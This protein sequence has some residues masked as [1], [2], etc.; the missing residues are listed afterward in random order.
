MIAAPQTTHICYCHTTTRYLWDYSQ[1]Y[2]EELPLNKFFK[3]IINM[4]LSR[5]RQWD[6]AA[7]ERVDFFIANSKNTQQRIKK[8]YG[9]DSIVIYPPV[10]TDRFNISE[11]KKDYFI[12]GGRLT[13]YK[14]FDIAIKAFNKLN[15]PLKIFGEGP[16]KK[17][18]QKMAMNNIE[19][20]G[21]INESDKQKYL[22]EAQAFIHPQ[23]EDF[24]IA[25][26]E[27]QASGTP[28]IAYNKGGATETILHERTGLLFNQQSW[29]ELADAVLRFNL[30]YSFDPRLVKENA[31]RFRVD[32]FNNEI[33]KYITEITNNKEC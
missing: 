7:A 19:F 6:K 21:K 24:G 12:T 20:L 17:R 25:A 1:Q 30:H 4:E 28:V 31:E 3:K 8:Y 9:R 10:D 5:L 23:E 29:E 14:R 32:R 22:A 26:I 13:P 18:L 16:D 11:E 2:L 15:L 33:V 27:A